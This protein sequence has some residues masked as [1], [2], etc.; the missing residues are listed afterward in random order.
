MRIQVA[1]LVL[2]LLACGLA[3]KLPSYEGASQVVSRTVSVKSPERKSNVIS[4]FTPVDHRY[5]ATGSVHISRGPSEPRKLPVL[6]ATPTPVLI[7]AAESRPFAAAKNS[8]SQLALT[9]TVSVRSP[10]RVSNVISHFLPADHKYEATG[11]VTISKGSGGAGSAGG[12]GRAIFSGPPRTSNVL[13]AAS[14]APDVRPQVQRASAAASSGSNLALTR[15]VSVKSPE[16]ISSVI[17]HF[18]PAEHRY[19]ATGSVTIVRGSEGAGAGR[20]VGS[21]LRQPQALFVAKP[22]APVPVR[23]A[24]APVRAAPAPVPVRFA[25][26]VPSGPALGAAASSG[27]KLALTRTV[28]VKSPERVSSVISHFTPAEHKY[29]ATGSVTIVR[30][31]EGAGRAVG[32]G[33]RQSQAQFAAKPAAPAPVRS[34]PAP[35]RAAPAPVRAAPAPAPVRFVA[36]AKASP[37]P[38]LGAASASGSKLALTRTVSVKSPERVSSVISHFTP[39]EHKYEATGSVTIVRGSEGAGRAVGSGLRQSQ[40]QFAAK[41]AAPAPVR[42]APA[43]VRAA[44]AP[45]RAAPAPTP[46]RFVA[47]A[48][49][50]PGPALGAAS[51]SGSKLALT[52]TVSVKSPERVSSVISHFTP[53]E[54]KYEATGS[55]TIVRGSE[56]AGRA[57]G[58]GLRQSQAQFVAKPA[59]P[60][61]VRPALAPVRAAPAPVRT[62][63]APAPAAPAPVQFVAPA[64]ASLGPALGAA[65]ASGSKLALTRTVSV[66][67]PERVSSVISHFT[68]AEHKYEATGSV[69]IV[70]GSE[71]AGRAVGSGLRQSQAQFVAK[72]AAPAPVRPALAPVRAAPAPVRTAPAPAPVQ[73]VAPAKASPGPALGAASASGSKLALTRTVS[74]KSPERVSSVVSHFTPAEHKYE[75][76]GSVTISRGSGGAIASGSRQASSSVF[77]QTSASAGGQASSAASAFSTSSAASQ[78]AVA[79]A[80][81]RRA[82]TASASYQS[83]LSAAAAAESRRAEAAAAESRRAEAAAAAQRAEAAAAASRRAEAAAAAQRAEAAAAASRRAEAAAAAQRAE[84]AAAASRRAQAEAAESQRAQARAAAAQRTEA[85]AAAAAAASRRAQAASAFSQRTEASSASY[86]SS[87]AAAAA[88][89][90]AASQRSQ[91]A[92]SSSTSS[93][94]QSFTYRLAA[95]YEGGSSVSSADLLAELEAFRADAARSGVKITQDAQTRQANSGSGSDPYSFSV[96]VEDHENTNYQSRDEWVGA[97]GITYGWYSLLSADGYFYNYSY[98]AHP[99]KGYQVKVTRQDSGIAMKPVHADIFAPATVFSNQGITRFADFAVSGVNNDYE[100]EENMSYEESAST[101]FAKSLAESLKTTR[102]QSSSTVPAVSLG[103]ASHLCGFRIVREYG[104]PGSRTLPIPSGS[105]LCGYSAGSERQ[106]SALSG[107]FSGAAAGR[108]GAGS[109]SGSSQTFSSGSSGASSSSARFS[110]AAAAAG[111]ASSFGSSSSRFEG[112]AGAS[113]SSVSRLSASAASARSTSSSSSSGAS[114]SRLEGSAGASSSSA[115]KLSGSAAFGGSSAFSGS[116]GSS[117]SSFSSFGTSAAASSGSGTSS[118]FSSQTSSKKSSLSS[119]ASKKASSSFSSSGGSQLSS[120]S[121]RGVSAGSASRGSTSSSS[122][123]FSAAGSA[124]GGFAFGGLSSGSASSGGSKLALSRTVS[125]KT[126]ERVSNVISHFLPADHR[127]EATGSV[128]INRAE[129]RQTRTFQIPAPAAPAPVVLSTPQLALKR[130]VSVKSPER[131]SSVISHFLPA[132]HKYEAT[133]SVVINRASTGQAS[134]AGRGFSGASGAQR[135]QVSPPQ[136][137]RTPVQEYAAPPRSAPRASPSQLALTRTVSVKSPQRVSSV[138]S[139]FTP[140]EH[141]YE[142]TGSV[143]INRASA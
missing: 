23:A 118:G 86:Q 103:P 37:G 141:K 8:A 109:S 9:R 30:G 14:P 114:S 53:A 127:Y 84:A 28:S 18:T 47:P 65:S 100:S 25:T 81:S 48:K 41:P 61:P 102:S 62:A 5:E 55:V 117:G 22:A 50:S 78:A 80:A 110:G 66:K 123:S 38:A 91:A 95:P 105:I 107:L 143:T 59:A 139:H 93:A 124:K 34:A 11:S 85:A 10:E 12:A 57:V 133:G 32:S 96:R 116:S 132:D 125:V 19:E 82:E 115:S 24:P 142:A 36:P 94:S 35:V 83:S 119:A 104:S 20:A 135:A 72:P 137:R 126:P 69:T 136:P 29:E 76:T 60:A 15:T 113:S 112:S 74:V 2:C 49:A 44:P 33:L 130:I 68:P 42:S 129:E 111:A 54:H 58:S 43:P 99:V 87:Q 121:S 56:G 89:A 101:T 122:S 6:P 79:A 134:S 63:P 1:I 67:S 4:H 26:P 77:R 120:L 46:V 3:D 27:S 97:D 52:R 98:T 140:A 90:A 128:V 106:G 40:A 17:S 92:S 31:S 138:I 75:A 73:F 131:V 51:A 88:A 70:R 21:G 13:A 64:K 16:R 108:Y 71:G 39:A 45:V 7:T